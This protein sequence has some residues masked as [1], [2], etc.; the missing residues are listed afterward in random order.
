MI[1]HEGRNHERLNKKERMTWIFLPEN[2][3]APE[4]YRMQNEENGMKPVLE[5]MAFF[6]MNELVFR[7]EKTRKNT[8]TKIDVLIS[9]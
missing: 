6:L 9:G 8:K 1:K 5:S 4:S 7:N 3:R 2:P